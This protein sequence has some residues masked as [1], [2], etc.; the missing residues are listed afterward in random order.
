MRF[1]L[2]LDVFAIGDFRTGDNAAPAHLAALLALSD[3][4]YRIGVLNACG[5]AKADPFQTILGL[6]E[7][8]ASHRLVQ[9]G[10]GAAVDCAIAI[11]FDA[12]IFAGRHFGTV[13]VTAAHRFVTVDRPFPFDTFREDAIERLRAVAEIA[14]GG[15]CIWVPSSLPA[16][17][18]LM[19]A[20]PHFETAAA[21][22]PLVLPGDVIDRDP[23]IERLL[24]VVGLGRVARCRP[25][26][27]D[28]M[29]WAHH[30]PDL[31]QVAVRIHG[32]PPDAPI[33]R[34]GRTGPLEQ[35]SRD[36]LT[37]RDFLSRIDYLA[38]ADQVAE[39][40]CP[41][42]SLIALGAGA[43]PVLAPAY[44]AVFGSAAV[45]AQPQ[46][47][48][49]TV[50][51]LFSDQSVVADIR[52]VQGD[53]IAEVHAAAGFVRR[54]NEV[55]PPRR[56][57]AIIGARAAR[58][59][60]TVLM[61]STNGVGMGHLTRQLAIARR[62]PGNLAPVFVSHSPA[63]H[64]VR[65]FGF[66][67]EF[68]PYHAAY[69]GARP[70]WNAN[71]ATT[72]A[73]MFGFYLPSVVVFDGN[74]PFLGLI[75][76]LE[77]HPGIASVWLRRAM[78]GDHRDLDALDRQDAFDVVIEPSE[79]AAAFDSG[80]TVRHLASVRRV[81]PVHLL[82]LDE[83]L[84]RHV[85]ARELGLEA[86]AVNVLILPGSG[87]N[88]DAARMIEAALNRLSTDIDG[89]PVVAEWLISSA[90]AAWPA[91]VRVIRAYPLMRWIRAF[92]FAISASG[93]N[94]FT[95]LTL[96]GVPTI[97]IAND[98]PQMDR[99]D[100]RAAFAQQ[101]GF[102]LCVAGT[103]ASRMTDAVEQMLDT[104]GRERFSAILDGMERANGAV[105]AARIVADLA[106]STMVDFWRGRP[107]D[108][109]DH[110]C[111]IID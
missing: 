53:L 48:A 108:L 69:G 106:A 7:A 38:N 41:I 21:D 44:R 32:A 76:A 5:P 96:H 72:L 37:F 52:A 13:M 61:L 81:P 3:A 99:Q 10:T 19:A 49:R 28:E 70:H 6:E 51:D 90:R 100:L 85:A 111:A 67:S 40:P 107:S 88:H 50:I 15:S 68:V 11:G 8:F 98:N 23:R 30:A 33:R 104:D 57:S 9:L 20:T 58:P 45:Y 92:D 47:I 14:L 71:L 87:N 60:R 66:P 74:V 65:E 82:D 79:V 73:E 80:P 24:P 25:W 64:K 101:R 1:P 95:E 54:I 18:A 77:R 12:R 35:W 91:S 42:E 86:D 78:W 56:D 63:V 27:A 83:P 75:E 97:W 59:R 103:D 34:S 110:E 46:H 109:D 2:R 55:A 105:A 16:R 43:V 36:R 93:Y 29:A 84:P 26:P 4:G 39:D 102:G 22:W 31:A 89:Q 94:S 17:V 62:L